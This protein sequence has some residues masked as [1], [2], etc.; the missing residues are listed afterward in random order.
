[1]DNNNN[2]QFNLS[3]NEEENKINTMDYSA[4]RQCEGILRWKWTSKYVV[5]HN[6]SGI[7][8]AVGIY[9]DVRSNVDIGSLAPFGNTHVVVQILSILSNADVLDNWSYFVRTWHI[10][11]VHCNDASFWDHKLQIKYNSRIVV[12]TRVL[13]I[14][15]PQPYNSSIPNAPTLGSAKA[16][17]VS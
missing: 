6:A 3:S 9:C 13:A 11:L 10:E 17:T 7:V 1:M 12:P 2:I 5:L 14:M 8:V 16:R 15:K 4:I